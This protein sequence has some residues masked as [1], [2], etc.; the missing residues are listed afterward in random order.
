GQ[1]GTVLS[2][3][4]NEPGAISCS[5]GSVSAQGLYL[6]TAAISDPQGDLF[7]ADAGNN[8]VLEYNGALNTHRQ[9]ATM[10][11]GQ[12]GDFTAGAADNP[13]RPAEYDPRCT[14]INFGVTASACTLWV[15]FGLA[16]DPGGLLWVAD[17]GNN[18]VLEFP[19]P[20]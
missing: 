2:G 9:T 17:Q 11:Y 3:C 20:V 4:P 15:P 12:Y 14:A 8:R 10:V 19:V 16:L 18:R 13:S 6:P 5:S 7:I 1:G